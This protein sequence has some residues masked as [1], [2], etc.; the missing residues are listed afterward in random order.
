MTARDE[1]REMPL[2][3]VRVLDLGRH[4]A[5][6]TAAMFLGDL[7]A[8]VIKIEQPETGEDGRSS[9]PPFYHGESAFFLSAN[10]NK[11]SLALD[12]KAPAGQAVARR[13][14]ATAD[15]IVENFRPGVMAALGLGYEGLAASNPRLILCSISGFGAD[16]PYAGRP[17][18]DNIIQ[19]LSGLMSVTGFEDGEPVRVGIPIADLLTGLLGAYGVLAALQARERTGLGQIVDTSLLEGMVGMMGF[20]ALRYL[21]GGEV[22]PPA[23]NHHPINAP[24]GAFRT[25]D[26]HVTIGATGEKRWRKLCAVI[27][28]TEL[29]AD[30]R[31]TTNGGRHEHRLALAELISERLLARTS[32]E[33]EE[34]LNAE[35]IPCGPIYRLDQT[36]NHPQVLHREMVVEREHPT[37]GPIRLLGLPVKLSATPGGVFR[38]PPAL[39]QDT[40]SVLHEI[41]YSRAEIDALRRQG[42]VQHYGSPTATATTL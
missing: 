15:V 13:V 30:P 29:L 22:A 3:G 38:A 21:N 27:G 6:P 28:A 31:F 16:G 1:T 19:G 4:L 8:D 9:G 39:G 2:M 41:G 14:A 26:G 35:G 23:G 18:L 42:V 32:D 24:Y 10:R 7:G 34:I 37:A 40:D 17:G 12:L 36:L 25:R 11:R 5:G 20:Q 33:W